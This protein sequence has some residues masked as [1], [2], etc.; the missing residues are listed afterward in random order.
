LELKTGGSHLVGETR[1]DFTRQTAVMVGRE[2]ERALS[3]AVD[4]LEDVSLWA[5]EQSAKAGTAPEDL[6]EAGRLMASMRKTAR[7]LPRVAGRLAA[8]STYFALRLGVETFQTA[9]K[10]L[11]EAAEFVATDVP[12]RGK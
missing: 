4:Q 9:R 8:A 5:M 10:V 1:G 11:H 12:P 7:P 2:V 6:S 3:W